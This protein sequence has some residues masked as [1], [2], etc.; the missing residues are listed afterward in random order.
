[1]IYAVDVPPEELPRFRAWYDHEHLPERLAVPGFL[2]GRRYVR[3]AGP[4]QEH[5]TLYDA[6]DTEVFSAPEYLAR[7]DSPTPLTRAVVGS[8]RRP[9]RAVLSVRFSVGA[10]VGA[11]LAVLQLPASDVPGLSRW[12]AEEL[13]PGLLADPDLCGLHLA[14]TDAAATAAKSATTEGRDAGEEVVAG[15]TLLVDGVRSVEGLAGQVADRCRTARFADG[16]VEPTVYQYVI[17][18]LP[19]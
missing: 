15:C 5:L 17:S 8:F 13:A 10:A 19:A 16:S 7:L 14:A 2:R 4:G 12:V 18:L 1:M 9:H 11:Q 6:V 3:T